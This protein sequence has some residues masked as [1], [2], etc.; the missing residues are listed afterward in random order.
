MIAARWSDRKVPRAKPEHDWSSLGADAPGTFAEG[1]GD[2]TNPSSQR[3][4]CQA[5][6]VRGTTA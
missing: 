3:R 4:Y 6:P 5:E 2:T 1:V